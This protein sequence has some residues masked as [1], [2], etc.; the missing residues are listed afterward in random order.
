MIRLAPLTGHRHED[1]CIL[2]RKK[3][4]SDEVYVFI[5]DFLVHSR[6]LVHYQRFSID[7]LNGVHVELGRVSPPGQS[8]SRFVSNMKGV[9]LSRQDTQIFWRLPRFLQMHQSTHMPIKA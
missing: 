1:G 3:V 9:L 7:Q 6:S 4:G 2:L 8:G 5:C